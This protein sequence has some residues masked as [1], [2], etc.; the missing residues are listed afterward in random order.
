[1]SRASSLRAV[2]EKHA[3][4]W[5]SSSP[6]RFRPTQSGKYVGRMKPPHRMLRLARYPVSSIAFSQSMSSV[7]LGFGDVGCASAS[8]AS[9]GLLP[10]VKWT[11]YPPRRSD[12]G[13]A[14]SLSAAVSSTRPATL[15]APNSGL[16][17]R[18]GERSRDPLHLRSFTERSDRTVADAIARSRL[19]R[20]PVEAI[21][22][23][24]GYTVHLSRLLN[25]Q[26]AFGIS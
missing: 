6:G 3:E 4:R 8:A 2:S 15:V 11:A 21:A 5:F 1:M 20:P 7:R 26:S 22:S 16:R 9:A 14:Y 10:R 13:I 18:S 12:P 19:T 23:P 24:G 25:A 17:G